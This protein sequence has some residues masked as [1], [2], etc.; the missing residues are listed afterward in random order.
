MNNSKHAYYVPEFKMLV[1]RYA[2]LQS[3][4]TTLSCFVEQQQ[5]I[6]CQMMKVSRYQ[7]T[8]FASTQWGI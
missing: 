1:K 5:A 6:A 4:P 7:R 3:D 2:E 8:P